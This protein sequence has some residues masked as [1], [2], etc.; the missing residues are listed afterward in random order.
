MARE[1][2]HRVREGVIAQSALCGLG[3]GLTNLKPREGKE[4]PASSGQHRRGAALSRVALGA[5]SPKGSTE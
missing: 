2:G 3:L 1:G 4:P 5:S